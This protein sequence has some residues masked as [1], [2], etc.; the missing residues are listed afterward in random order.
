M[1][2]TASNTYAHHTNTIKEISLYRSKRLLLL[3]T[4]LLFGI[5]SFAQDAPSFVLGPSQ[6]IGG[7]ENITGAAA[8]GSPLNSVMAVNDPITG[9]VD[10]LKTASGPLHGTLAGFPFF[11]TTT[12]G[13][14]TP[15]GLAYIPDSGYIGADSFIIEVIDPS[16]D[17]AFI[18]VTV[19]SNM[20][21]TLSSTLTP[22][23]ICDNTTFYYS[24]TSA[25]GGATFAWH[26]SSSI[27]VLPIFSESGVGNVN[28]V[29]GNTTFYNVST[30][31]VYTVTAGGCT[32]PAEHVTVTI[33]PTPVLASPTT[34]TVCSGGV[35][36]YIP[37][38]LTSGT[39]YTWAR[40]GVAGISPDTSTGSGN[41][42]E[43]LTNSLSTP[44]T[45][46]YN[47][48]L[49]A[50]GC[51]SSDNVYITV[52]PQPSTPITSITTSPVSSICAGTSFQNFGASIPAPSGVTYTWSATNANIYHTGPG[53]QYIL[54]NFPNAGNAVVTLSYAEAGTNCVIND[55]YTVTV[56]TGTSSPGYVL[57]DNYQFVFTDNTVDSYQW[58]YDNTTT[59]D[60][61]I[62]PG[63]TFQSYVN[64]A[65]DYIDNYYW[66][67]TTKNGCMQKTYFNAPSAV[68]NINRE[69]TIKVYP[70]P[71]ANTVN[72]DLGNA[73]GNAAT[74]DIAN[75]LGQNVNTQTVTAGAAQVDIT[76]LPP[77]CYIISCLQDGVKIASA[78][79]IKN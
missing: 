50:N 56:G 61:T 66:V 48:A 47:F 18:T 2:M 27:G 10:T 24:P 13:T 63:A 25:T 52:N 39:T 58:G 38:S 5:P 19:N 76:A 57:Y 53:G 17:I 3:C 7:C 16:A 42:N 45:V 79:L 77:G 26:R 22:P 11:D 72:I 70:N 59:L 60:S 54:V 31:Y 71:A 29:L 30:T 32:G 28:E 12:G 64:G 34:D 8:A 65:P 21:P 9:R 37:A 40:A 14:V 44:V 1:S 36:N 75:M 33:K 15:T 4:V 43:A 49:A 51:T 78:R 55:N 62:I 6:V 67:L 23:A 46:L 69:V 68:T 73:Q 20:P 35:V 41:I 74:V